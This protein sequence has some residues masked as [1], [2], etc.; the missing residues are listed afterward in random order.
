[1]R[2]NREPRFR[3]LALLLALAGTLHG[4][5]YVPFVD[6]HAP[7]DSWTYRAAGNAILDGSYSTPL[8]AGF[9]FVYPLGFFDIT[10]LQF[11][12]SVWPVEEPQVFRPP[13]YPLFLATAGG[14][15]PGASEDVA[16][17]SG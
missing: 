9:Y 8:K 4:L 10:G 1:M 14:G 12:R 5:V 3:R 17:K 13:G 16:R 6:I 2:A 15:D 7:T 11:E